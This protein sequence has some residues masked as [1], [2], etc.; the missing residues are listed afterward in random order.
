MM[1]HSVYSDRDVFLRELIS[2]AADAI[3]VGILDHAVHGVFLASAVVA[4]LLVV[5]VL[6]MPNTSVSDPAAA[7]S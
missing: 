1:V 7:P 5:A 6:I 2:N 3:P 4:V